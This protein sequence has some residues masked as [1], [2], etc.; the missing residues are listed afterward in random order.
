MKKIQLEKKNQFAQD[1][2]IENGGVNAVSIYSKTYN[3]LVILPLELR[4]D[5][6]SCVSNTRSPFFFFLLTD[7]PFV[8]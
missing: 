2:T 8:F 5:E 6:F 1:Y 3:H 7:I 4:G